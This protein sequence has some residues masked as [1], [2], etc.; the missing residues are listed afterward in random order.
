MFEI[1]DPC[2]IQIQTVRGG[3]DMETDRIGR[4]LADCG[5][6]SGEPETRIG[7]FDRARQHYV[8]F[9]RARHLLALTASGDLQARFRSICKGAARGPG[10]DRNPLARE[11]FGVAGAVPRRAVEIDHLERLVV[12]LAPP[13]WANGGL[14]LGS[15]AKDFEEGV[16]EYAGPRNI[17]AQETSLFA[18]TTAVGHP[19]QVRLFAIPVI[20]EE[21]TTTANTTFVGMMR[22]DTDV[23]SLKGEKIEE[24]ALQQWECGVHPGTPE[25]FSGEGDPP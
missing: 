17:P 3:P 7:E 23:G 4:H 2:A 14:M 25:R 13:E 8:A 9:A 15:L 1:S 16:K 19:P 5:V 20:G 11:R 10:V 12:R 18:A 22:A 21:L 6:Y 24:Q